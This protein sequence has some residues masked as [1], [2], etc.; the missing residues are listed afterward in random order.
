MTDPQL[1]NDLL[2]KDPYKWFMHNEPAL[3]LT[4]VE[5]D[6]DNG[7]RFTTR[8]IGLTRNAKAEHTKRM[9]VY[10]D[11]MP[12]VVLNQDIP[13]R[14]WYKAKHE[15]AAVRPRPCY[16]EALLTQPYG[17]F[18]HVGCGFCYINNGV[19][20]YRSQGVSTV[21]PRY[22]EKMAK[23]LDKMHIGSAVYMSSFIDPFLPLEAIYHNTEGTARAAV[24]RGLPIF[25]L[26]R[27]QVPGWA[28][29]LLKANPHSYQQFSINTPNPK[30]WRLLSPRALEL[31]AM[32]D[33]VR[34][35]HKRGIYVSIQV[36]PIVAGVV[37]NDDICELIHILA[38]AGADHLI[39]KFVEI[40]FTSTQALIGNM[41]SRFGTER[42]GAFKGLFTQNIGG[43]RTIDEEYRKA[44][45]DRFSVE[46][47]KAG[48]TMSLCYEYEFQR[49]ETGKVVNRTGVNLGPKYMTSDQCHGHRVPVYV[50]RGDQF[51]PLD[52]CPPSGCLTCAEQHANKVPC[53]DSRLGLAP[54][55]APADLNVFEGD[56]RHEGQEI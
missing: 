34:E 52:V 22:A 31:P 12:H 41:V 14:G 48:V 46:C 20:G 28:Y 42:G 26:T 2:E 17:G 55:L 32:F 6:P 3:N 37:T 5:V 25:F 10:L 29:D 27:L 51:H 44:A 43:V 19:R 8:D 16:T 21:D 7:L 49:D 30:D 18:C 23:Q 1:T 50:R 24:A 53:G 11:P 47:R 15:P 54:A 35:M 56:Y 38:Q 9:K 36:N 39:F 4:P 33:Q 40:V 13:L 45:L